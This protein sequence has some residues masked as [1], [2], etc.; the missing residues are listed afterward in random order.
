[1]VFEGAEK[2][3]PAASSASAWIPLLYESIVFFLSLY[4]F[5]PELYRKYAHIQP[6]SAHTR[7]IARLLMDSLAYYFVILAITATLTIMI[8]NSPQNIKNIVA[9]TELL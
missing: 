2:L 4:K 9:Q 7:V 8:T 5:V 1:M 6:E 3:H